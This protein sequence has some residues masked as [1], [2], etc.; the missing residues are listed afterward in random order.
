MAFEVG[1][2]FARIRLETREFI[3]GVNESVAAAKDFKNRAEK[4]FKDAGN[5]IVV[6]L[7]EGAEA[8]GRALVGPIRKGAK[9]ASEAISRDLVRPA[10]RN[11]RRIGEG[12]RAGVQSFSRDLTQPIE[13]GLSTINERALVAR[14]A[15]VRMV[16]SRGFNTRG[17]RNA[18]FAIKGVGAS[19]QSAGSTVASIFGKIPQFFEGAA[20]AAGKLVPVIGRVAAVLGPIGAV[21]GAIGGAA[22]TAFSVFRQAIRVLTAPLRL[23]SSA[24]FSIQ[25]IFAIL[26]TIQFVRVANQLETVSAAFDNLSRSVGTVS[27]SFLRELRVATRGA[28]S[29]LELMRVTN[30]AVLLGVVETQEQFVELTETARRL[31]RALGRS[32]VEALNDLAIGI[33]RQSRLILDNLGLVVKV[34]DATNAYARTLGVTA[35]QLTE[36]EKRTAFLI[37]AQEA[38]RVKLRELGEDA[39]TAADQ[40]GRFRAS[41]ANVLGDIASEFVGTGSAF[42]A[43]ADFFERNRRTIRAFARAVSSAFVSLFEQLRNFVNSITSGELSIEDAVRTIIADLIGLLKVGL[44]VLAVFITT[45]LVSFIR[46]LPR[47]LLGIAAFAI[48]EIFISVAEAVARGVFATFRVLINSMIDLLAKLPTVLPFG[49]IGLQVLDA[50]GINAETLKGETEKALDAV[51]EAFNSGLSFVR[52]PG[53][54]A[55]ADAITQGLATI[56][57]GAEEAAE[58]VGPLLRGQIA[59]GNTILTRFASTLS[60]VRREFNFDI[61][62]PLFGFEPPQLNRVLQPLQNILTAG[63]GIREEFRNELGPAMTQLSGGVLARLQAGLLE[64]NRV[65]NALFGNI[66]A[67]EIDAETFETKIARPIKESIAGIREDLKIDVDASDAVQALQ[68]FS[69]A[70]D[71]AEQRAQKAR[72]TDVQRRELAA[73]QSQIENVSIAR[74]IGRVEKELADLNLQAKELEDGPLAAALS[75]IDQRFK[76]FTS[77]LEGTREQAKRLIGDIDANVDVIGA[78]KAAVNQIDL[79]EKLLNGLLRVGIGA[80]GTQERLDR[81]RAAIKELGEKRIAVIQVLTN[82][83]EAAEKLEELN[84]KQQE[85][86]NQTILIDIQTNAEEARSQLESLTEEVANFGLT[87]SQVIERQLREQ[88]ERAQALGTPDALNLADSLKKDLQKAGDAGEL[89]QLQGLTKDVSDSIFSGLLDAF[90]RG[91]SLA[92]S[93]SKIAADIFKDSMQ[94]TF[95][96]ISDGLANALGE[97]FKGINLPN[98]FGNLVT[99]LIGIAAGV[100]S[101][102]ESRSDATVENF[103]SA[104]TSSEAIRGVVA[105][106]SNVAIS[107]VGENLKSALTVTEFW[108]ERIA[109]LLEQGGG[110]GGGGGGGVSSSPSFSLSG[111]TAT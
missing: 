18:E 91:E 108:L 15:L 40:V 88:I 12:A 16:P 99:G 64:T 107:K 9:E 79:E 75:D 44:S 81:I 87:Q 57:E 33:G 45:T 110:G 63:I 27:S 22:V 93:W 101:N 102:L 90:S 6:P 25:G 2:I 28:V 61:S 83:E 80:K 74:E 51:E 89:L 71:E 98:G 8:G 49:G 17:I 59:A 52:R 13:R 65:F 55:A 92:D 66:A 54:L 56:A 94:K 73:L 77:T 104:V 95:K 11:L 53:E 19:A 7:R 21:L 100:L 85:L 39:L 47:I 43:V 105:G 24:L 69:R 23:L 38:A 106:P 35:Q 60:T 32:P 97:A 58:A 67:P 46:R 103:Q 10:Q 42:G 109:T 111:S 70:L 84:E 26:G 14:R 36:A 96:T 1:S 30:N 68:E 29:D 78:L 4:E 37:A 50:L 5:A 72:L 76:A 3:R 31:G 48:S 34:E 82:A 62:D 86:K 20:A 41:I